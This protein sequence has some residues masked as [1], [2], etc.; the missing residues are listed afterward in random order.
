VKLAQVLNDVFVFLS[1]A[2]LYY[3]LGIYSCFAVA[4]LTFFYT[5]LLDLAKIFLDPLN[6]EKFSDGSIPMDLSVIIRE[7]NYG[8]VRWKSAG[9]E[10]PFSYDKSKEALQ[11][12]R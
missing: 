8:S 11:S 4:I 7:A 12:D 6:N 2:A 10:L 1:P 5:G 9:T 3:D